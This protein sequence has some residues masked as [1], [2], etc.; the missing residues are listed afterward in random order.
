MSDGEKAVK[1]VEANVR[2][3]VQTVRE[4]AEVVAACQEGGH[5][6]SVHGLVY[7][8]KTGELREISCEEEEEEGKAR[9][10]AFSVN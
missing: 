10:A 5:G 4:H 2:Q 8:V 9:V 3:G 6:V 7:D 1:L